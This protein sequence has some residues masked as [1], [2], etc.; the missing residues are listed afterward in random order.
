MV[1]E[2]VRKDLLDLGLRNP[3]LNYR[4]LK[5]RGLE[6]VR[7]NPSVLFDSLVTQGKE[8]CFVSAHQPVLEEQMLLADSS[9]DLAT[10]DA[11]LQQ[12]PHV[13]QGLWAEGVDSEGHFVADH[14]PKE[15]DTRLLATYYTS[16]ASI[17]EQGVNT[18]YI[19]LGML[20]WRDP[21]A[22]D[23]TH[24]APILLIPVELERQSA[25]AGFRVRY[26]GDDV[27]PNICLPEFLKQFNVTLDAS[28]ESDD[29][30]LDEYFDRFS[31]A[32]PNQN[33][34]SIDRE[35]IALGFF[36]FSK[37]LMYRD[38]DPETWP[39][40][41]NLLT[42]DILQK[43][44]GNN[45]FAGDG[46]DLTDESFLDDTITQ[47]ELSNV[48]DADSSQTL[49]ILDTASGRSMVIQG[50]P[51]TGKSQT[52][53]NLIS[54]ALV[55]G[56]KVLFVSEKRAALEV[57]KRR[58]DKIGLGRACL[59]LH[60]NKA[61]KKEVIADLKNT[62]DLHVPN[63]SPRAA[64]KSTL[65]TARN[66]LNE[67][68]RA[69]NTPV[70]ASGERPVDLYG[71]L[72]PIME[73]LRGIEIPFL[74]LNESLQWSDLET[75]QKRSAVKHL[76]ARLADTGV[77][78][79][80][81][82]WGSDVRVV[83]PV[84]RE[85]LRQQLM[86][87]A[88][89]TRILQ[90]TGDG[91]GT[92][93]GADLPMSPR[94]LSSLCDIAERLIVAPKLYGLD[95]T[96]ADWLGK[97][98]AIETGVE[99][100]LR[101]AKITS[102]WS[103]ILRPEAWSKDVSSSH[104]VLTILG[105]KWWR[106]LSP[107]WNRAKSAVR[108]LLRD[109]ILRHRYDLLAITG[110]IQD[111]AACRSTL[112]SHNDLLHGL[113]RDF[114]QGET[115]DWSLLG[116]Q[117]DWIIKAKQD[118]IRG[119]LPEWGLAFVSQCADR[120][121]LQRKV[122]SA[123]TSIQDFEAKRQSVLDLLKCHTDHEGI[124]AHTDSA[125]SLEVIAGI[126]RNIVEHLPG[127]DALAVYLQSRDECLSIGL[128]EIV[129]LADHW[130][131]G[132][133]HLSDAFEYTR[134]SCLLIR[135]FEQFS[136]LT[137]FDQKI[138]S[139]M[140][141]TFRELD[142]K[143]LDWARSA[144]AKAHAD[145]IPKASTESGQLGYLRTMFERKTRFPAIRKLILN[146]GHAIQ[147]F[148]PV[149][150]M[151]PLSVAN[152]IPPDTIGFDLVI[153][154]EASQ[155]R[156]AEALGAIVR[157]KQT[158]VVGDSKQL[159]PTSFFDT[160]DT[161]D[162]DDDDGTPTTDIESILGLFCS[163]SAH[164]RML[165]W[166]YRS[167]HESLIAG[168]NYLFY[169]NRLVVFPS[170]SK[171]TENAGLLYHKVTD[172]PYDRS[173][174]RTNQT[175]ARIVAEAVMRLAAEQVRQPPH[176]RFTLGVAALSVAQRDAILDQLEMLRRKQPGCEEFFADP[177]HEPFFV[178]N[179]E[180]VQGD[181]RDVIFISIGYG[182]TAEGYLSMGFG[183]VNR[184]GGER[185]LNV[186][187][188]RARRRCEVFTTLSADDIDLTGNSS[189]GLRS[190]KEFLQYAETGRLE[191][192]YATGRGPD[193]PF[194]EQVIAALQRRGYRVETQVG[195]AGFFIDIAIID[196]D[197]P[198]R[199]VLGIECDGAAYHSA[200]SARDRDRLRQ[201]VLEGLGWN[202]HRIWSTAWFRQQEREIE[203]LVAAIESAMIKAKE[204]KRNEEVNHP[205]DKPL[206]QSIPDSG[207]V[208]SPLHKG[209]TAT[210]IPKY[211]FAQLQINLGFKE[212]HQIPTD[213]IVSWLNKV[214]LVEGPVHW[215]EAARR[216]ANAAGVQR[217]GARI[218]KAFRRACTAG[219][220][221]RVFLLKD[222]FLKGINQEGCTIR[223]RSDLPSQFKKLE[224][225]APEEICAAIESAVR[226]SY[227]IMY[228]DV[229]GAA[230]R[231]LG[232]ARV[233][234]DM[235]SIAIKHINHL[236]DIGRLSKKGDMLLSAG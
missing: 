49:A 135:A 100:G 144:I 67:Y 119:V 126:W 210:S 150:M 140:V 175:E 174:T 184:A 18:L 199:Y 27:S 42:H 224:Y 64:D 181:E 28:T 139:G 183:P 219:S 107:R 121:E 46:S 138:H 56:K 37:F 85:R 164:Q 172:A 112:E 16:R 206:E 214:A 201:S 101:L 157:G 204:N 148:K 31:A 230:C 232:F 12:S 98:P 142:A 113:Y 129:H 225:V 78:A 136:C 99:S 161:I 205:E 235:R 84:T 187:F 4:L 196:P 73:R 33:A 6:S 2:E 197:K 47:D 114:W 145:S 231:L 3:L 207:P 194:E 58:L 166:H 162:D 173:R 81:P 66:K 75:E 106:F 80:H 34:W 19:A 94:E 124:S 105:E 153:F 216:I 227:G 95:L 45:S 169:D 97:R 185:R 59:E 151:S 198:G 65:S 111:A 25:S 1:L 176:S 223:D 77:P 96:D 7:T 125:S 52:I 123:L 212:L 137:V 115:S 63:W 90:Q 228:D 233:T 180:N 62:A 29:F 9:G 193:S 156:P 229:P 26:S 116:S 155:V 43:L 143:A 61:K 226:E 131:K 23:D 222:G 60:S 79:E 41:D 195:C 88:E 117:L 165:R 8:L 24:L 133:K 55:K 44:L 160:L 191:V 179:L 103:E 69:V 141:D 72:L 167:R 213:W 22:P 89:A 108:S 130:D 202:L 91:L 14:P 51:G 87:A 38:L 93:L 163:R 234:E 32:I 211:Q 128:V 134:A 200:R 215:L 54:D 10:R 20:Q 190:L 82:F 159:P 109:N 203:R 68:C 178:K 36:S 132:S 50:P 86:Q 209:S 53:V 192:P 188:S 236:I 83:L 218:Q 35:H 122:D 149:F 221:K 76:E 217:V 48:V 15:L 104:L 92:L 152:F 118:V 177:P 11:G 220:N 208:S 189:F 30:D 171:E 158:V 21:A 154:D 17:E 147:A 170:P 40:P 146:A 102:Q 71:L 182:R 57:V 70:G 186:L 39:T 120:S 168:S 13:E 110:A 74:D 5:S 127:L